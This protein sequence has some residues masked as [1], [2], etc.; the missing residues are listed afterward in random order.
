MT[1]SECKKIGKYTADYLAEYKITTEELKVLGIHIA[2]ELV[3]LGREAGGISHITESDIDHAVG[4]LA[5]CMTLLNI[6]EEREEYE[7]CAIMK[8]KIKSLREQIGDVGQ[9]GG[10]DEI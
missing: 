10:T 5:R 8:I 3:K 2:K 4:E 6:Y 7:K 9:E 1:D